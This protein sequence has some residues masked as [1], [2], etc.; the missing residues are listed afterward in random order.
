MRKQIPSLIVIFSLLMSPF[1]PSWAAMDMSSQ[2]PEEMQTPSIYTMKENEQNNDLKILVFESIEDDEG[3]RVYA[4]SIW[5]N[6]EEEQKILINT[7]DK[8]LQVDGQRIYANLLQSGGIRILS[9]KELST[10]L[11]PH[12][13]IYFG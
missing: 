11:S 3:Q 13:K 8:D 10:L 7:V 1:T 9:F 5:N 6:G 12:N 2:V 4:N